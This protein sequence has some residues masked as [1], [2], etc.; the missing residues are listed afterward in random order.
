M[1]LPILDV[2]PEAVV[3]ARKARQWYADKGMVVAEAFMVELDEAVAKILNNPE[4]W[5]AHT[6]GTRRYLLRRFPF[7]IVY[8]FRNEVVLVVA[9]AHA[10]RKPGYWA[11]R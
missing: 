4:R 10:R 5:P 8:R 2:H 9:F 11:K 6:H 1:T 7:S 3:E